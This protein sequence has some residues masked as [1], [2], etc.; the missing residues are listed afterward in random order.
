MQDITVKQFKQI[1]ISEIQVYIPAKKI[2]SYSIKIKDTYYDVVKESDA[3]DHIV[4]FI[5]A[6]VAS[7]SEAIIKVYTK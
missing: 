2:T 5:D 4:D 1:S 3:Q 6:D 7:I